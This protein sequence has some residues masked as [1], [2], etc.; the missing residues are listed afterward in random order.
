MIEI[1]ICFLFLLSILYIYL[2]WT[3]QYYCSMN[4]HI[5]DPFMDELHP[6]DIVFTG[7]LKKKWRFSW[8]NH[9]AIV[10]MKK[11]RTIAIADVTLDGLKVARPFD[12]FSGSKS[13][14]YAIRR[15]KA[16]LNDHLSE[17]LTNEILKRANLEF[18]E[19]YVKNWILKILLSVD[20]SNGKMN[21]AMFVSLVLQ[22]IGDDVFFSKIKVTDLAS[23]NLSSLYEE[24]KIVTRILCPPKY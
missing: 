10:F 24:E 12:Y 5:M 9:V 2:W 4:Y 6:G 18:D 15:R 19:S 8:W 7:S 13:T 23:P 1:F 11:D 21:C 17:R 20:V 3:T 16:L 22:S 14:I